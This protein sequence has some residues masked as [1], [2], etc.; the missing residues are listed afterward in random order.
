[1]KAIIVQ[2]FG[3]PEV[4]RLGET[5]LPEPGPGEVRVRIMAAGVNPADTYVRGGNYAIKPALPYTPGTDGAGIVDAAGPGVMSVE[6]GARVWLTGSITGTYAEQA[7]AREDQLQPLPDGVSFSQG[8]AVHVPYS[9]AWYALE[10]LARAR[11]GETLLVHGASGGV[12]LAAVQI[13][14]MMGLGITGT[15]GTLEGRKLAAAEGASHVLDH[16]AAGF[17]DEL[18]AVTGG[19]GFDVILEMRADLNLGSD[20]RLLARRG[21]VVVIGS[22]GDVSINP[23]D[24][25]GREG[26]I[27]AMSLWNVAP[28]DARAAH[29][30][31]AA[32]LLDGGLRPVVGV[33]LPLAEAAAAHRRVMEPGARGK[34]VLAP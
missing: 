1:M 12:G 6:P 27:L 30:A 31:V 8:A 23:R 22:R 18:L 3:G 11:R 9:T 13:A 16:G 26:A 32:G 4:L 15:A 20:L 10:R 19:K 21:R 25:M 24:L 29:A 7:L 17:L 14:R 5:R 28:E 33:E 2:E 34:I